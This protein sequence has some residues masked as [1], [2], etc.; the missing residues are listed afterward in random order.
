MAFRFPITKRHTKM[1]F[2]S[3]PFYQILSSGLQRG[4]CCAAL[5]ALRVCWCAAPGCSPRTTATATA[6][7]ST[8]SCPNSRPII[9]ESPVEST[10][11]STVQARLRLV[12]LRQ[13]LAE[14]ERRPAGLALPGRLE[15][16]AGQGPGRRNGTSPPPAHSPRDAPGSG[17][18]SSRTT[19]TRT[20]RSS[21][22]CCSLVSQ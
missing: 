10:P 16:S 6:T 20:G 7:P 1:N 2:S 13:P 3:K 15:A 9:G 8:T 4:E 19:S 18:A 11:F 21:T 17:P 5:S 12:R 22:S 14:A